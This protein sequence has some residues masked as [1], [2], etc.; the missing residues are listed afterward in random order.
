[1]C[2]YVLTNDGDSLLFGAKKV[3]KNFL[4]NFTKSN[5]QL[6]NNGIL[7]SIENIKEELSLTRN[8]LIAFAL[9]CGCDYTAGIYNIG[10]KKALKIIK[11]YSQNNDPN[12]ILNEFKNNLN[13]NKLNIPENFPNTLITNA[14]LNPLVNKFENMEFTW[15]DINKN[16]LLKIVK[17]KFNWDNNKLENALYSIKNNISEYF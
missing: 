2:D 6:E 17:K 5:K 12:E 8:D 9:L 10:P 1:M 7:Y 15:T 16:S 3:I 11:K 14:F 13:D 4:H